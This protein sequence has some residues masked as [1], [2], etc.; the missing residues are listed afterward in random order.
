MVSEA[1]V[2]RRDFVNPKGIVDR[3][4]NAAGQ[5]AIEPDHDYDELSALP[6]FLVPVNE[7]V[8]HKDNRKIWGGNPPMH[9]FVYINGKFI[10]FYDPLIDNLKGE[11]KKPVLQHWSAVLGI[12][13]LK[14]VAATLRNTTQRIVMQE[15]E[16]PRSFVKARAPQLNDRRLN[17]I[18]YTDTAFSCLPSLHGF[19]CIQV[20]LHMP[21]GK[22]HVELMTSKKSLP[23]AVANYGMGHGI[24]NHLHGDRASELMEGECK[25]YC[26][27]KAIKLTHTGEAGKQNQNG[28]CEHMIGILKKMTFQLLAQAPLHPLLWEYAIR[29]AVVIWNATSKRRLMNA[30]PDQLFY[31]DTQDISHLRFPFGAAVLYRAHS[32]SFP[33][34]T[35][36]S[37]GL[38]LGPNTRDGDAF[39]YYVLDITSKR[40][41]SRCVVQLDPSTAYHRIYSNLLD[42][43][44]FYTDESCTTAVDADAHPLDWVPFLIYDGNSPD[45]TLRSQDTVTPKSLNCSRSTGGSGNIGKCD[46]GESPLLSHPC[47]SDLSYTTGTSPNFRCFSSANVLTTTIVNSSM[48]RTRRSFIEHEDEREAALIQ[49][50]TLGLF[51]SHDLGMPVE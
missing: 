21:S 51:Q 30:S 45:M 3:T 2:R 8:G 25:T 16:F 37:K 24:P 22:V 5:R 46:D 43:L 41:Y 23:V 33:V 7:L 15:A 1:A 19:T 29:Y 42:K 13:D 10:P 50:S 49:A 34:A 31:G 27:A 32:P 9:K 39:T 14:K 48:E 47:N 11:F 26:R 38:Y 40:I 6:S 17:G 12:S 20:F 44:D 35:G 18:V 28:H 36:L 4:S